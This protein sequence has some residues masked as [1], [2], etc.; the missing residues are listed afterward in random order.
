MGTSSSFGGPS[1]ATPLIPSWLKNDSTGD[2]DTASPE[3]ET[4]DSTSEGDQSQPPNEVG[5]QISPDPR[6][7]TSPRGNFT[8][9]VRSA[10]KDRRSLGRAVS[11]Y[12]ATS[13]GGARTAA[14]RMGASRQAGAQLLGF[15][16]DVRFK[17]PREALRSWNL[18]GLTGR[19][20]EEVFLALAD[21]IC[22]DGGSV[23]DGIAREAYI[24]TII[25]M[26]E[27]GMTDLD[28]LNPEQILSIFEIYVTHAVEAR[29]LNDIGTKLIVMPDNVQAVVSIEHQ[30]RD[31]I[32]NAVSDALTEAGGAA[33]WLPQNRDQSFVN[34][35]YER[36]FHFLQLLGE[37]EANK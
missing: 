29:I 30:L 10:G 7:F 24:E 26:S 20:I 21:Y 3:A 36:S 33:G 5:D 37:I 25:A 19:P 16:A 31:F 1:G 27:A 14:Q 28:D 2:G 23:D 17:G 18:E 11:S 35:V 12:V 15:L 32:Q 4:P 6:R 34:T 8:R 9:Y 13:T 22:P